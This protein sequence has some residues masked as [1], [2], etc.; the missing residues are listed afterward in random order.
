MTRRRCEYE[1]LKVGGVEP[2]VGVSTRIFGR[3]G[4]IKRGGEVDGR[5]GEARAQEQREV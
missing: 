2:R 1:S 3:S 4:L 5:R